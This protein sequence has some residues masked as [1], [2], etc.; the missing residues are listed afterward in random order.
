MRCGR[1]RDNDDE[2]DEDNRDSMH[3][4]CFLKIHNFYYDANLYITR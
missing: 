1:M 2:D 4:R 3:S